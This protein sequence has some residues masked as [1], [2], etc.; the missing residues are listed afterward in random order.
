VLSYTAVQYRTSE[1]QHK[2]ETDALTAANKVLKEQ[3]DTSA[4]QLEKVTT[5]YVYYSVANIYV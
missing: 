2:A 1:L 5:A 3:S 4:R